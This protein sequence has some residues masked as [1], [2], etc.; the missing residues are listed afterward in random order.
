MEVQEKMQE[1]ESVLKKLRHQRFAHDARFFCQELYCVRLQL[2]LLQSI[3]DQQI[4]ER[5]QGE[6]QTARDK[7]ET[8]E[9]TLDSFKED[10]ATAN[11][12]QAERVKIERDL[13]SA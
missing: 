13:A 1:F 11:E 12:K 5:L 4:L 8:A 7:L 9:E 10:V 3:E 2:A 6:A